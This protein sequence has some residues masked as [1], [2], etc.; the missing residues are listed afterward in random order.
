MSGRGNI[1]FDIKCIRPDPNLG[2]CDLSANAA[3]AAAACSMFDA[4][5]GPTGQEF[6]TVEA[7]V[8]AGNCR[9]GVL[10]DTTLAASVTLTQDTSVYVSPCANLT[11]ADGGTFARAGFNLFLWGAQDNTV[12]ISYTVAGQSL[13]SGA[14]TARVKDL[15]F[16]DSGATAFNWASGGS[17]NWDH[18]T[19][20][21]GLPAHTFAES[22]LNLSHLFTDGDIVVNGV[23]L[24]DVNI[25]YC[26]A[27]NS[28]QIVGDNS[29]GADTMDQCS[30]TNCTLGGGGTGLLIVPVG[31]ANPVTITQGVISFNSMSSGIIT[32]GVGSVA[33]PTPI[34]VA[35][36]S[37]QIASNNLLDSAGIGIEIFEPSNSSVTDNSMLGDVL[38]VET[39]TEGSYN[40][41]VGNRGSAGMTIDGTLADTTVV[42]N[43][44]ESAVAFTGLTTTRRATI[45]S[46]H[47]LS[48][49]T[50]SSLPAGGFPIVNI[51]V[52]D[53]FLGTGLGITFGRAVSR[54]DIFGNT[55]DSGSITLTI[56]TASTAGFTDC[57]VSGNNVPSNITFAP[58]ATAATDVIM[59]DVIISDNN[60]GADIILPSQGSITD[61]N[62]SNNVVGSDILVAAAVAPEHGTIIQLVINGN[63]TDTGSI[64]LAAWTNAATDVS[65]NSSTI[66]NNTVAGAL[67]FI[68]PRVAQVA[69]SMQ[70]CHVVGNYVTL[71]LVLP[72]RGLIDNCVFSGNGALVIGLFGGSAPTMTSTLFSN[73][74][75]RNGGGISLSLVSAMTD[76]VF[77]GNVVDDPIALS[78]T[79]ITRCVA[80][81]NRVTG[82]DTI[83]G[84][85]T[86]GV[87]AV[88]NWTGVV[89]AAGLLDAVSSSN[90]FA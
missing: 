30:I 47:F 55:L 5:V 2:I 79:A 65:I 17:S 24:A 51:M 1:Q 74:N 61:V 36:E 6:T 57:N 4:C 59:N 71:L 50:I 38:R 11:V 56:S 90:S 68:T 77:T 89:I 29:A 67:I 52:K 80:T 31:T 53:N 37:C 40:Q 86:A 81:G 41:F 16:S 46:N 21:V 88:G 73:N 54:M 18:V 9:I 62:I 14:G 20:L 43:S 82:A 70:L 69:T 78:V 75:V 35:C 3:A 7:A 25:S 58:T 42:G 72:P 23:A 85:A 32:M 27:T 8:A 76:C 45:A 64:S 22:P 84:V 63:V 33:P 44:F 39:Y 66:S 10:G 83:T 15:V 87:L 12:V 26:T 34:M 48:G 28:I 13:L 19:L 49:L 60:V